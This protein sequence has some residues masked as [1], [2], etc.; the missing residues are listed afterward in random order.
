MENN[1]NKIS[2]GQLDANVESRQGF[3]PNPMLYN[4][5]CIGTITKCEIE[6]HE[7]PK[8][9]ADGTPSSWD[10]AGFKTY[11]LVIEFKQVLEN[12]DKTERYITL[13][14]TIVSSKKNTGEDV[15][16]KVWYSLQK[17]Q[18]DRLQ[19]IVN[20]LDKGKLGK[21]S[22]NIKDLDLEYADTPEVRI[23]KVKKF[24]EHFVTQINGTDKTKRWEGAKFWMRVVSEPTKGT[25]YVI[26]SFVGKG[27][28]E[29]L[30]VNSE[31]SIELAV[32]DSIELKKKDSKNMNVANA[33][34]VDAVQN[35]APVQGKSASDVLKNLG[36]Q[37]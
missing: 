33:K 1:L 27:F 23:A 24:F 21:A 5:L 18:F 29:V 12:K 14:E 22:T 15:T 11:Q 20:A 28:I 2:F 16:P 32:N 13:R 37:V 30:N 36:I 6:E 17:A 3:K 31:P 9:L 35:N 19:H 7:V 8:Q 25:Y 4:G 34:D 10:M 26:P